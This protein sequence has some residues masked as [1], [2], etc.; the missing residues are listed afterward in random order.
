MRSAKSVS[1]LNRTRNN[2]ADAL[3]QASIQLQTNKDFQ[4]A[5]SN[6]KTVR[7]AQPKKDFNQSKHRSR[8]VEVRF[9]SI[10]AFLGNCQPKPSI[11][12]Y[13]SKTLVSSEKIANK[14]EL[15][16]DFH[17]SLIKS[18]HD[19]DS[20]KRPKTNTNQLCSKA[21][22]STPL[23]RKSYVDPTKS[24]THDSV[25]SL[26]KPSNNL[27]IDF[28]ALEKKNELEREK[29]NQIMKKLEIDLMN[30]KIDLLD[31]EDY[32]RSTPIN[33]VY[34]SLCVTSTSSFTLDAKSK[35]NIFN[36]TNNNL[37][38]SSTSSSSGG[39]ISGN[40]CLFS[41]V[42]SS[43][44]SSSGV[45]SSTGP[46][47]SSASSSVSTSPPLHNQQLNLINDEQNK[48]SSISSI[49][50]NSDLSLSNGERKFFD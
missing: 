18:F 45:V 7:Q 28:K 32:L 27:T 37:T 44:S 19:K 5:N 38:H 11:N 47:S 46:S 49:S 6:V 29:L 3:K 41:S 4:N 1:A 40:K 10:G 50:S 21:Q 23:S 9:K 14:N 24:H 36:V 42:S 48:L 30:A 8:S 22:K 16:N 39:N 17:N 13:S 43:S 15:S 35:A 26:S 20:E 34:P 31:G 33:V 25:S 2:M 12:Q